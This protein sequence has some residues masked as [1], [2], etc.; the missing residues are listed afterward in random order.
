MNEKERLVK[1]GYSVK[2]VVHYR[3]KVI[4]EAVNNNVVEEPTDHEEIVLRGF[5]FNLFDKDEKGV[6][7]EGS[8]EFTYLLMVIK[9][10]PGNWKTQLNIMNQKVDED[11]GK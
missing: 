3:N 10:W 7:R 6:G 11:N 1:G 9:L 4:W 8:S 5:D 2:V